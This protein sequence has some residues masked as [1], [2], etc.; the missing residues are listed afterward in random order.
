MGFDSAAELLFKVSAD[1]SDATGNLQRFRALLSKDLSDMSAEFG[2]WSQKVF[3]DVSTVGGAMTALGAGA[4]AGLTVAA[5]A[6][7]ALGK[8][9]WDLAEKE[10]KYAGEIEEGTHKTGLNA[11]QMSGLRYAAKNAGMEYE[12]LVQALVRFSTNIAAAQD[13]TSKQALAF[14]RLDV[15]QAAVKAGTVDLLP[16]LYATANAMRDHADGTM[17]AAAA[18][19]LFGRGGAEMIQFLNQGEEG[20]KRFTAEAER[21]GLVLNE[22]DLVAAK[23]FRQEIIALNAEM[24]GLKLHIG[25]AVLPAL[26]GLSVAFEAQIEAF[27]KQAAG[28]MSGFIKA[29]FSGEDIKLYEQELTAAWDRLNQ[30]IAAASTKGTSPVAAPAG[31][32]PETL[33]G[34]TKLSDL[35]EQVREKEVATGSEQGKVIAQ[36]MKLQSE[37]AKAAAE[38][39]A[40]HKAGKISPEDYANELKALA[41][42]APAVAELAARATKTVLDKQKEAVAAAGRELATQMQAQQEETYTGRVAAWDLEIQG[43]RAQYAEKKV[44]TAENEAALEALRQA[45]YNKLQRDEATEFRDELVALQT[46]L[47]EL[48]TAHFTSRERIEWSYAQELVKYSEAEE[49]KVMKTKAT[50]LEMEILHAQFEIN[51]HAALMKYQTDLATLANSTGWQAVFGARFAQSIRGN[52]ELLRQWV[53]NTGHS[54]LMVRVAVESMKEGVQQAFGTFA[55]AMG[56]N[57]ADAIVYRKSLGDA[58]KAA[59]AAA[60][61][62]LAARSISEAIFAMAYGWMM[63]AEK[64]FGS[65]TAAWTA[66]AMFAA[67]GVSAAL[68][69]RAIAPKQETGSTAA[70]AAGGGT[71]TMAAGASS[72]GTTSTGPAVVVYVQGPIIGLSGGQELAQILNDAV[73]GRDVRL[74]ASS[75]RGRG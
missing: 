3:G 63:F 41:S 52:E 15:S 43:L 29:I 67:L 21:L 54:W 8:E 57:I 73:E 25:A 33:A 2:A 71:T 72:A 4:L 40:V 7:V 23:S 30:R 39:D 75:L 34:W 61:E 1:P 62:A 74:V 35:L 32:T 55:D 16:L 28:G 20:M 13:P 9:L 51:R 47:A 38:L 69:G 14:G 31:P 48:V 45:G 19:E 24:E 60:L 12:G 58:L 59:A 5:G 68:A 53:E 46:H 44:L 10:A 65:A 26:T 22:Y 6:A 17:K 37:M 36:A 50:L 56:Q 27:K 70:A 64:D 18:R 66:S 42:L 49:A 11:E